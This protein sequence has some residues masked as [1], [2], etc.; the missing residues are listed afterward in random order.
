M[1]LKILNSSAPPQPLPPKGGAFRLWQEIL[2]INIHNVFRDS[3]YTKTNFLKRV[4]VIL[5][6]AESPSLPGEGLGWGNLNTT[7]NTLTI[8][9]HVYQK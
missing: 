6:V 2:L 7:T 8:H 4:S 3:V 5:Q 1:I 9:S